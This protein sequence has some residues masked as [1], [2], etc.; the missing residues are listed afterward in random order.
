M[1][2]TGRLDRDRYVGERKVAFTLTIQDRVPTFVN[3]SVVDAHVER[4]ERAVVGS[5]C[6]VPIYC[7][8]PD[9]MHLLLMGTHEDSD[10]LAAIT[11]YKNLSGYWMHQQRLPKWQPSFYDHV[12][13]MHE[14]WRNQVWYIAQNPVRAG[15]AQNWSEYPFLGSLGCDLSD[16]VSGYA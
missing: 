13:R 4:L 12:L 14:D 1:G 2:R 15:L 9:H 6:V 3:R 8:M 11:K 5:G 16:I 10:L 7:Y